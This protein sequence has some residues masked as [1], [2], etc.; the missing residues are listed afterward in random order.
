M[1]DGTQGMLVHR[2]AMIK[3]ANYQGID[4]RNLRQYFRQ[5]TQ[6]LHW[7]QR[8]AGIIRAENLAEHRPAHASVFHR[9]F[10]MLHD[11]SNGALGATAERDTDS[12]GIR[13][14]REHDAAVGKLIGVHQL[15]QALAHDKR[16]SVASLKLS[17]ARGA[18]ES[19]A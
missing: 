9:H 2:V 1:L 17:S 15:K 18:E 19:L 4:T 10:R 3:I 14:Q 8:H 13:E 12:R 11:V 6:A 7:P 16:L 5:Q